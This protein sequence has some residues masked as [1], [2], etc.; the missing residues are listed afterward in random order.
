M[1]P[2]LRIGLTYLW[3]H[4]RLP[5]LA[6]P[7]LFTEFVQ[8]R[9]LFDRDIRL[10]M[11]ADKIAAKAFVADRL[12]PE[13]IVPTLWHGTAL[14]PAPVWPA[15]FVVKSRHGCNQT[16][17][18]RV[19]DDDWRGVLRASRRWMR[20]RYGLWLDEWLYAGIERGLMVEPF[21]GGGPALPIDYKLFVFAGRV[22][23]VQVHLGRGERHRWIV[24]DR[25][26]RRVSAPS[27]DPDP[28]RPRTLPAMIAA[29]ETL[30]AGFDFVRVDLYEIAGRPLF[31]EMTFYPGSGL[32]RFAPPT[33]DDRMGRDWAK[34]RAEVGP[35]SSP[36]PM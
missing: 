30:A 17:F 34:A 16:R 11:L 29:A 15:P 35:A 24:L 1:I 32:H 14:P 5:Q 23:Y 21:L 18:W 3:R 13:W 8:H 33:L 26:W 9:K 22:E 31:G 10:P 4:R 7:R 28:L 36:P 20:G 12:G 6:E 25:D 19:G 2:R 27:G